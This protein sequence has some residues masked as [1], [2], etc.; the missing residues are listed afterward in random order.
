MLH[1]SSGRPLKRKKI[2]TLHINIELRQASVIGRQ[3]KFAFTCRDHAFFQYIFARLKLTQIFLKT[4]KWMTRFCASY[5]I[6]VQYEKGRWM[7][8]RDFICYWHYLI[9]NSVIGTIWWCGVVWFGLSQKFW[10]LIFLV[11]YRSDIKE[12]DRILFNG[13]LCNLLS[14]ANR[15]IL[16]LDSS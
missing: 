5:S 11:E 7:V 14:G 9:T 6:L 2:D 1:A 12:S 4:I 3:I 10:S 16:A 13:K 8:A 15:G